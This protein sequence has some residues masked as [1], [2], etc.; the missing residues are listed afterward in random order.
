MVGGSSG[1]PLKGKPSLSMLKRLEACSRIANY[2]KI[3]ISDIELGM[4]TPFSSDIICALYHRYP[5]ARFVWLMGADNLI[6][7]HRWQNWSWIMENIPIGV[8]PRPGKQI[9]AGLS[10]AA[11]RYQRYRLKT[12]EAKFL[13]RRRAPAWL[14]LTGSMIDISSTNI[15][16]DEL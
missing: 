5:G 14:L 10:L 11:R 13:S 2:K 15:R 9:R 8:L 4:K 16:S 12:H 3:Y 1:N 6:S 7:F